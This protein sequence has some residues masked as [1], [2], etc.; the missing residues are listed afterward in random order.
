M[1]AIL[2][3]TPPSRAK[4]SGTASTRSSA[5]VFKETSCGSGMRS[6]HVRTLLEAPG[7]IPAG[8]R[9]RNLPLQHFSLD[10]QFSRKVL[11]SDDDVVVLSIQPDVANALVRRRR[12]GCLLLP[13]RSEEW[14]AEDRHWLREDFE[15]VKHLAVEASMDHLTQVIRR[16]RSRGVVHVLLYNMCS[17][18]PGEQVHCH[19][20]LEEILSTRIKRFNLAAL[21]LSERLGISIVDVDGIVARA[22][23]PRDTGRWAPDRG[24]PPAGRPGSR[25][26]PGGPRGLRP[27]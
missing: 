21:E 19:Q 16:I 5:H 4:S 12:D 7:T 20:G 6:G 26:H 1:C 22:R 24:R 23:R 13:Y 25:P 10:S 15:A 2:C 8:L 11:D 18:I 27:P 17:V 3:S 14:C 9:E